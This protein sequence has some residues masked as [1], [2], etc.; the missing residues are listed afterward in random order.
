[1]K[2]F[3]QLGRHKTKPK[4]KGNDLAAKLEANRGSHEWRELSKLLRSV[5]YP[6]CMNMNECLR[7]STSVHHLKGAY[8]HPELYFSERNLIPLCEACHRFYD[9]NKDDNNK[10]MRYWHKLIDGRYNNGE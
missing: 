10:L 5:K 3:R 6:R 1:M 9:N 8:R 4:N 7:P 2:N